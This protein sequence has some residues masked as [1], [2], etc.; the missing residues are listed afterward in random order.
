MSQCSNRVSLSI[1]SNNSDGTYTLQDLVLLATLVKIAMTREHNV[2]LSL[3]NCSTGQSTKQNHIA[4]STG[5]PY[6]L[7][8]FVSLE[9][10]YIEIDPELQEVKVL[11]GKL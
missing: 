1:F 2:L 7:V 9:W 4:Y 10:L 5:A 3:A 8:W 11:F 6:C